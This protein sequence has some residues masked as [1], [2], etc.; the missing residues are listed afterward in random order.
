[1]IQ[2]NELRKGV[3]VLDYQS[4]IR[5]VLSI[6]GVN[7]RCLIKINNTNSEWHNCSTL[8]PIPI[9]EDVL[10]KCGFEKYKMLGYDTHFT[11]SLFIGGE[12]INITAIYNADFSI[13]LHGLA[14][15]VKYLHRLQNIINIVTGKDL[16]INL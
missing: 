7:D 1:M 16:E 6:D 10:L 11:Y 14:R 15:G 3:Y 4:K 5:E 8:F 13:M 2:P 12:T 9:T